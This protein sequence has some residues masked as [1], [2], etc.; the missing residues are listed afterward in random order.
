MSDEI[1]K[2]EH[3]HHTHIFIAC[4]S[5]VRFSTMKKR[6][7]QAHIEMA[8]GTSEQNREYVFKL[9]KYENDKGATK[10]P[11][12]QEEWGEIPLERQGSRNDITDLYD[13]IKSGMSDYDIINENP[14]YILQID[15]LDKTR[16]IIKQKEY[17]KKL[18]DIESTYIFGKAGTGK[19]YS[20]INEYG[21]ENIYR[22]TNYKYGG[23]DMYRGQDVIV[24]EEFNSGFKIQEMLNYL[25]CYPI[26]LPC[27]YSNKIACFTK[28]FIISNIPLYMQYVDVQAQYPET[29]NAFLRR[30]KIV[31][32]YYEYNCFNEYDTNDYIKNM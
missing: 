3:T 25:D 23:F 31:R 6:F 9:G 18:R 2:K 4:S 27:R 14:S 7:P 11:D 32:E 5:G 17:E 8:R 28:V 13:M 24:F 21:L 12:T 10:I 15:K 19:T 30:I 20:V 26:E 16:Q 29:W 1:G 22:L